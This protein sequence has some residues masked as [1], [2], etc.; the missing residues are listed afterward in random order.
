M[1]SIKKCKY[2][3]LLLSVIIIVLDQYTKYLAFQHLVLGMP[4]R[5]LPFFNFTLAFNTGAAF[6]FLH[7]AGGWQVWFFALL[8]VVICVALLIWFA[9]LDKQQN[10]LACGIVCIIG[11]AIG[12]V[13]DRL[14]H[15]FVID[16]LDF[17]LGVWHWP[18]FNIADS[19]IVLGV[20]LVLLDHWRNT[21]K[22]LQNR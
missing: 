18:V 1:S 14:Y 16:F 2:S 20:C 17:H 6:S 9:K 8:A 21:K 7:R 11:G 4:R 22:R 3:W 19:A 12:N 15:G 13:I 10:L 5:I